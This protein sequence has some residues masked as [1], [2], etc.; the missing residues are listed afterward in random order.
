VSMEQTV[1]KPY[2]FANSL[3]SHVPVVLLAVDLRIYRTFLPYA[4]SDLCLRPQ[5]WG[6]IF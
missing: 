2:G 6:R 1:Q 4:T 5:N 3:V